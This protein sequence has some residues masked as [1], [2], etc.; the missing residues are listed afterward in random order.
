[1]KLLL[2]IT[3]WLSSTILFA[4]EPPRK[5]IIGA[6]GKISVNGMVVDSVMPGSTAHKAGLHKA[7]TLKRLNGVS[8]ED[9]GTYYK[10]AGDIRTGDKVRLQYKRG[11]KTIDKEIAA[12]MRPYETPG[13]MEVIYGWANVE[14]CTLRTIVRKPQGTINTPAILF[15][16]G[17]NC[18][19]VENFAQG[20]YGKLI[21]T[22]IHAGFTVVTIE[23]SGLGDSYN[24]EPCADADLAM[25][26]KVFDAGYRYMQS[27]PYVDKSRLFIFGH[28]MGG[29]IAPLIAERYHPKGV[30]AFATVFR[31]WSEFLLEM[32]R[33]Q[34][35]LDGK[36]YAETE[37]FV[38]K[39]QKIYYEFFV[40]KKSPAELYENPEYRA[41][42]VS[43]LE[44]TKPGR[45]D[46]W[47]RHWRFWQ[48]IDSLDLARSWSNVDAKVLSVFGGADFV[49]CSELEHEL[50]V[51]T[52]NSKYPGNATHLNIPDVDHLLI[53]NSDW[54]SAH[55]H[56]MDAEYKAAHFHQG[57]ADATVKW[58][59][60]VV[61]SH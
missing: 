19:S 8:I 29:V 22:W 14:S 23:K 16:P 56:F 25:D 34:S 61:S 33:I 17:Y 3:A 4:Q 55:K 53:Q 52:V 48:Q 57:F 30:I 9:A 36:S 46:M 15:I 59:Q 60:E 42:V 50:I 26:I 38:R 12:I 10:L 39:M 35:P 37:D 24:C 13:D 51:R 7:D 32:H 28:S 20:S 27:L 49:A 41:L 44:Y 1:M 11:K 40:G 58:L 31:P 5:A 47:G 21:G 2:F 54:P 18:G 43:D 45:T 6:L